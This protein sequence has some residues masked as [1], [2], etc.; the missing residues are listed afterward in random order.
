MYSKKLG[1]IQKD[2]S[3]C[4]NE[5]KKEKQEKIYKMEKNPIQ[6]HTCV[7]IDAELLKFV[8]FNDRIN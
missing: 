5:L 4:V 3:K 8:S 1:K 7:K 2:L 6:N